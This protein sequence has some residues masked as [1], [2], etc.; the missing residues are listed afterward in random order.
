VSRIDQSPAPGEYA[1]ADEAEAATVDLLDGADPRRVLA[2]L[3]VALLQPPA[4]F[5]GRNNA[6]CDGVHCTVNCMC[7]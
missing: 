3:R 4:I 5:C 2:R 7:F 1:V 6:C